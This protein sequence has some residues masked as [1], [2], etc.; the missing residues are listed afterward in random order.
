MVFIKCCQAS[1]FSS[2]HTT[3]RMTAKFQ[4]L[5]KFKLF[6]S[7]VAFF[8]QLDKTIL[9]MEQESVDCLEEMLKQMAELIEQTGEL[10]DNNQLWSVDL[11]EVY[12]HLVQKYFETFCTLSMKW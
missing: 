6:E 9:N 11:E 4:L 5:E 3:V 7:N 8:A 10:E 2:I 1:F 12:D